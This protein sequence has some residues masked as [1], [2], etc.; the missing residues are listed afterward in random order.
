MSTALTDADARRRITTALDETLFV[1]AGAGSGKTSSLVDR[2][3]ATVLDDHCRLIQIAAITFTEKAA[4]E[5]RDRLRAAFERHQTDPTPERAARATTALDDLDSAAIGTLHSFAQRILIQHPIEAGLPPL[6]E[7]LDEVGSGLAFDDRWTTLRA[8]LLD[9]PELSDTLLLAMGAGMH[10]DDLRSLAVAFNANWDLIAERVLAQSVPAL[11]PIDVD[12]LVA[13]AQRILAL[14]SY[15]TADNDRLLTHLD[16]LDGWMRQLTAAPDDPARLTI[17]GNA[18]SGAWRHGQAGNWRPY[19]LEE[20]RGACRNLAAAA[21]ALRDRVLEATLRRLGHRIGRATIEDADV[22]RAEG[23]LEFHD[24]LVL[25]RDLLRHPNHG[26]AVRATLHRRYQRLLLDEFQDT[27]PIQ[28]ELAVRI[29]GG[30]SADAPEWS[31]VTTGAGSLF[32][33]GDPKQSIYRFR[34]ADIATY[35]HAQQH[36]GSGVALDTNFRTTAPI[37]DWINTTFGQLIEATPGSQPA[38]RPLRAVRPAA[39]NGPAVLILGTEPHADGPSADELRTR[40]AADVVTTVQAALTEGWQVIDGDAWRPARLRDIAVLVPART[41]LPHLEAA[42]DAAGIGFQCTASSLVYRTRE[43]RDLL[44]AARAADDPSDELALVATLRSPLFGCGDDDLWSWHQAGGRFDLLAAPPAGLGDHAVARAIS[45][46]RRLHDD[47]PWLTPSQILARLIDDRR[48]FES[49][50]DG[51]RASDVWRRLRFVVDQARAFSDTAHAGLRDYLAWAARQGAESA[52]VAEPILPETDSESLRITTI[53]AA[54]GLEFPIV[55]LSG[56]TSRAGGARAGVEVLWPREGGY[57]LKLRKNLQTAAYETAKPL[58]EQMDYHERLRLLYVACT[59]AR[60]HLAVSL[61]RK[62]RTAKE[63]PPPRALTSA[64]LLAEAA[65]AAPSLPPD[66]GAMPDVVL[67]TPATPP[68]P[69]E[70]WQNRISRVRHRVRQPSAISASQLEGTLTA[71]MPARTDRLGEPADPGLAKNPRD[72]ELPP[73]NKGRYGTAIGRAVHGVLQ[74]VDLSTGDGL[75]DAVAAQSLAEGV[76][77]HAELIS[78]LA[79]SALEADVVQRAATRP[80]WRETYVGTTIDDKVLEGI[81]D[82]LYRDDD[83]LVIVDYKTD[84]VPSSA[85]DQRVDYYRPQMAAYAATLQ[86]ATAEEIARCILLFLTPHGAHARTVGS[87]PNAALLARA[88]AD[89]DVRLS[90]APPQ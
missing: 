18:L 30:P 61:H 15:C 27:D 84:A 85:L 60:D 28:I 76:S 48:M 55:I 86:N 53:H 21:I 51:P 82:L 66:V 45:Y 10:L 77:Q 49:A 80:H 56:L 69:F 75:T 37:L 25:A 52:R 74:T 34:R 73:W 7:V 2:V 23:R 26:P 29:A 83:G 63:P 1:E 41:S 62:V 14:R 44:T 22:R 71:V 4:A 13:E 79:R 78:D 6:T 20:L 12:D 67:K 43:I 36:L 5:L 70:Q 65:P 87:L 11:P 64:E 90:N 47:R 68:P 33:V 54:K 89:L 19:N 38:Y 88:G 31:E 24:L 3:V 46:L 81:I 42:L 32:L 16:K 8:D 50:A 35:L 9:D 58:D 57:E 72:L 39:P 59:R 40:E 17:L